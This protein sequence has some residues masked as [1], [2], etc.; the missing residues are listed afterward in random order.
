MKCSDVEKHLSEYI[1]GEAPQTARL[2]IEIHLEECAHCMK[3]FHSVK[4]MANHLGQMPKAAA[5]P[6]FIKR[7]HDRIEKETPP[8]KL[9]DF[10][11]APLRIRLPLELATAAALGILIFFIVRPMNQ[12]ETF[13]H[14]AEENFALEKKADSR[15][16]KHP[17][18]QRLERLHEE[19]PATQPKAESVK[20]EAAPPPALSDK[21]QEI[22]RANEQGAQ[23]MQPKP[24]KSTD[25][26]SETAAL[27]EISGP[28]PIEISLV[29]STERQTAAAIQESAR[30]PADHMAGASTEFAEKKSMALSSAAAPK[31]EKAE[32]DAE[33]A[34]APAE[35]P[36]ADNIEKEIGGLLDVMGGKVIETQYDEG[37][38]PKSMKIEIPS[39]KYKEF[40][41]QLHQVGDFES[42]PLRIHP[43]GDQPIQITILF[44]SQP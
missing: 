35:P 1:D 30:A 20:D 19:A 43:L 38:R 15:S 27:R 17:A 4:S 13:N 23:S 33:P 37:Y 36:S 29:I 40:I 22:S 42:P 25:A 5:P 14:P 8:N 6:D 18:D 28:P 32:Q 21:K 11:L 41:H 7:L 44:L 16:G 24:A 3:K 26:E 10:F 2:E 31:R 39:F 12:K 34:S 9:R